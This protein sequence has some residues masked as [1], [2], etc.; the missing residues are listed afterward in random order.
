[1][2]SGVPVLAIGNVKWGYVDLSEIDHV[3]PEKAGQLQRYVLR[4]AD[5]LFTRSAVIPA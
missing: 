5:V 1:V 4:A 3:T 2:S